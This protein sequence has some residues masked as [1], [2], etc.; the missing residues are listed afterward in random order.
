MQRS[1]SFK[2]YREVLQV[3]HGR[4]LFLFFHYLNSI[5][6]YLIYSKFNYNN[7]I[8]F[9]SDGAVVPQTVIAFL[10]FANMVR[11]NAVVFYIVPAAQVLDKPIFGRYYY[12]IY[13]DLRK[14][15]NDV[16]FKG[17]LYFHNALY[18]LTNSAIRSLFGRWVLV[19]RL[20]RGSRSFNEFQRSIDVLS[21]NARDDSN[22]YSKSF[23]IY[24]DRV[25]HFKKRL[26]KV[27]GYISSGGLLHLKNRLGRAIILCNK[28]HMTPI[29][30]LEILEAPSD[31]PRVLSFIGGRH[32]V[33][34]FVV[35]RHFKRDFNNLYFFISPKL[36]VSRQFEYCRLFLGS[37]HL[38]FL[39]H[40]GDRQ[41][42][43]DVPGFA[44]SFKVVFDH[45]SCVARVKPQEILFLV[46]PYVG[47]AEFMIGFTTPRLV[48]LGMRFFIVELTGDKI[49]GI[50]VVSNIV[51]KV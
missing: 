46:E 36:W 2:S 30:L 22:F 38:L 1:E 5:F 4:S 26:T 18:I 21:K 6:R 44:R 7:F 43:F 24:V 50:G 8:I 47:F 51:W 33:V 10:N 9:V 32:K 41:H 17:K 31:S 27:V 19:S 12:G 48:C 13:E 34:S 40:G 20:L 15:A 39:D 29:R 3:R 35:R 11:V 45:F 23:I 37:V 49:V 42:L 25:L 16:G 28:V 14:C